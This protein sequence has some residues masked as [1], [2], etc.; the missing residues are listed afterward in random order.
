MLQTLYPYCWCRCRLNLYVRCAAC[1]T[2]VP[3]MPTL[4]HFLKAAIHQ[5][6]CSDEEVTFLATCS[7]WPLR[8]YLNVSRHMK[9][10]MNR[11][12]KSC[13]LAWFDPLTPFLRVPFLVFHNG[14]IINLTPPS[15]S[16]LTPFSLR[17][18]Y[19]IARIIN[20]SCEC[21]KN[22]VLPQSLVVTS[23]RSKVATV[24]I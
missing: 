5:P 8:H 2:G 13:T 16:S 15:F 12:I 20:W 23:S 19:P 22:H 14:R 21:A 18:R 11:S 17:D 1:L 10:H 9:L 24:S 6:A 3:L 7:A 4:A